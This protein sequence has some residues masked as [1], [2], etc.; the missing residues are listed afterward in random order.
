VAGFSAVGTDLATY[1]LLL[2]PIGP[3]PAKAVSFLSACCVAYLLNKFWTFKAKSHSWSEM[4]RFI[5][6]YTGTFLTNVA[7]NK[8]VIVLMPE[9]SST[10]PYTYQVGW[11]MATAVSTIINYFGQKFWVFR[12]APDPESSS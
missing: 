3:S 12:K 9:I 7:V 4:T 1:C 5:G 10:F 8:L 2:G 11:L 6:L